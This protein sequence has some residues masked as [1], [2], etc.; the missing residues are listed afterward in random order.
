[1][2]TGSIAIIES[3][4]SIYERFGDALLRKGHQVRCLSSEPEIVAEFTIRPYDL[5]IGSD[6]L[7]RMSLPELMAYLKKNNIGAPVVVMA[8]KGVVQQ[9]IE[10]IRLGAADYLLVSDDEALLHKKIE[11]ILKI[12]DKK[13]DK[14]AVR[15]AWTEIITQSAN[16]RQLL[17]MAQRVA[18]S[19]AT[20]LIQ[21]ESGTG[22]ELLARFIHGNSGRAAHPFVAM[23]CA[24]L[25]ENLAESELFG[26]ERGAFTGA[27]QRKSGKFE[28]AQN[29]T[30]LLDEISEMPLALQAK[31]LRV[32]QEKEV[33]RVGGQSPIPIDVRV[34]ATTNRDL[35]VMVNEGQ[36]RKD[37]YYRLRIIPLTIPP[38]RERPQDIP[39]LVDHFLTKHACPGE[40]SLPR[41]DDGAMDKLAAWPW[42]GNVRELENTV[43]RAVL[44]RNGPVIESS[45]LLLDESNDSEAMA[46]AANLVG[47][48]VRELEER[49]INQ[50]LHHVHQNRTHAAEMLGISIRTLRNKLREYRQ[51]GEEP[52]TAAHGR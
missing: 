27:L 15:S 31:L 33:D 4:R 35:A 9:A 2:I 25:P 36:F 16:M 42:P 11:N 26:Y 20:V 38:L 5:L 51:D 22:K 10:A 6:P 34:I 45:L 46:S 30:L 3:R 49:L 17:D 40:V 43:E 44:L 1:M 50:T 29:G 13:Q 47:L 19:A 39:L 32:L 7:P 8:E 52:F 28:L 23:N 24:A 12:K 18:P 14:A 21:G 48:T 41:F 37:L